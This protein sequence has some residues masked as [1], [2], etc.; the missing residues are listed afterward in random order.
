MKSPPPQEEFIRQD[1]DTD[2]PPY[3]P[4]PSAMEKPALH[5]Q[6][7]FD[8]RQACAILVDA[9]N[10]PDPDDDSYQYETL[11][12]MEVGRIAKYVAQARATEVKAQ[13]AV[14]KQVNP[15][16]EKIKP[17]E[18][19][20]RSREVQSSDEQV[21]KEQPRR[22][23]QRRP[24]EDIRDPTS[25]P[26][27]VP[28]HYV[29]TYAPPPIFN[30][31][32]TS[33]S[34][35]QS[36]KT[37]MPVLDPPLPAQPDVPDTDT[38]KQREGEEPALR[39]IRASLH[40][41]PKTSAAACI[42]Y[43][44]PSD[45]SSSRSTSRSTCNN[46]AIHRPTSTGLSSL[47]ALTP[48]EDKQMSRHRRPSDESY[49]D[50]AKEEA[51]AWEMTR[52]RAEEHAGDARGPR[53]TSRSSKF[54]R[55]T[56]ASEHERPASRAGSIA[57]S[58]AGGISHY[59][60][61]RASFATERSGRSSFRSSKASSRS[62]SR[63]S[64]MSRRS[65]GWWRNGGLRRKGSWASFRSARPEGEKDKS[66]RKNGEP[67]LNRPLPALPG[68]DQYR[69]TKTHIGQLM[70]VGGRKIKKAQI[71]EPQPL[72]PHNTPYTATLPPSLPAWALEE[73][74]HDHSSGVHRG[75]STDRRSQLPKKPS[76]TSSSNNLRRTSVGPVGW[77]GGDGGDSGGAHDRI[78]P[79]SNTTHNHVSPT[80]AA[81]SKPSKPNPLHTMSPPPPQ[82]RGPS[83]HE[84]LAEG[85]Y[86]R[87]MEVNRGPGVKPVLMHANS[88]PLPQRGGGFLKKLFGG[89]EQ[90]QQQAGYVRSSSRQRHGYEGF[91]RQ[92]HQQ[93]GY[94]E[95]LS[96][97]Q[98]GGKGMFVGY[99]VSE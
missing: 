86:P 60:R 17:R 94:Q 24:P 75:K 63:S 90:Q 95:G 1:Y 51:R 91:S 19:D 71:S 62:G 83:Y 30:S 97:G 39:H 92:G 67:N 9:T 68:L 8:L 56:Q 20:V 99:R 6:L 50:A 31:M 26:N 14:I 78:L 16:Q 81:T 84:E 89:Q 45:A 42:D 22:Y 69:E 44:D 57:S 37:H 98:Q 23:S 82:I 15:R 61:P 32:S 43:N 48:G 72:L 85:V 27:P 35:K 34:P 21:K 79:L 58:I 87:P 70:K 40:A 2:S 65:S 49:N 29:P 36:S 18:I 88:A 47:T 25:A 4:S 10:P 64:S 3:S 11:K 13:K 96:L 76:L 12:K 74:D 80:T 55:M 38:G 66:H 46:D 93:Q 54:S 41:R 53:S 77:V 59:M 28:R 5:P 7:A 52:R 33:R 73:S